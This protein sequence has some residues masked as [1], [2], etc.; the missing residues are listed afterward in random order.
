MQ[1]NKNKPDYAKNKELEDNNTLTPKQQELYDKLG[2]KILSACV[3][4]T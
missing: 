3:T 4:E 1:A 2:T